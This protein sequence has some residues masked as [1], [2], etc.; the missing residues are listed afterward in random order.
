MIGSKPRATI[1]TCY[2][3]IVGITGSDELLGSKPL[4]GAVEDSI[5]SLR[6]QTEPVARLRS[7]GVL[8]SLW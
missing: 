5:E 1:E 8:S 6:S 7:V 3:C 2:Q 4:L